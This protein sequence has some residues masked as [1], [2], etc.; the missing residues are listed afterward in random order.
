VLKFEPCTVTVTLGVPAVT[1]CGETWL[2]DGL[3]IAITVTPV[4]HPELARQMPIERAIALKRFLIRSP[5]AVEELSRRTR[6]KE[7]RCA[8]GHAQYS[9]EE[10]VCSS[11]NGA[12]GR[13]DR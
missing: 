12:N 3:T 9:K 4:P 13:T 1:T 7:A 2:I 11:R 8:K 10:I 6:H 5:D